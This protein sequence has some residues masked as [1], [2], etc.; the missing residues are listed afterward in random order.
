[1]PFV[2]AGR[3]LAHRHG[4][5][6]VTEATNTLPETASSP[7]P[8]QQSGTAPALPEPQPH[9]LFAR[10]RTTLTRLR[11]A[12]SPTALVAAHQYGSPSGSQFVCSPTGLVLIIR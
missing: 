12:V 10:R 1:M 7:W 11:A 3:T 2:P 4:L 9:P 8:S 6:C 5:Q